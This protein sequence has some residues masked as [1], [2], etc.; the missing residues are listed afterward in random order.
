M[1]FTKRR[2]N[3]YKFTEKTHSKKGIA[4]FSAALLLCAAYLCFLLLAFQRKGGLSLYY[5]SAGVLAMAG[6]IVTLTL[7]VQSMREENSFRFFPRLA[8]I[9][10]VLALVCWGGTY[11]MGFY[12]MRS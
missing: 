11:L 8:L 10:S 3:R 7:S 9:V 12:L 2:R 1:S 4:A 6:A 5:G